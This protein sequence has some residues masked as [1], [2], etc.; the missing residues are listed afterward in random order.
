MISSE[1][2]KIDIHLALNEAFTGFKKSWIILCSLSAIIFLSQSWLPKLLHKYANEASYIKPYFKVF[3]K[4][5]NDIFSMNNADLAFTNLK[6][7]LQI[8]FQNSIN[9]WQFHLFLCKMLLGFIIIFLVLCLLYI[10]TIYISKI[11][12]KKNKVE[13][14][15]KK[16]I[17]KSHLMTFSYLVLSILKVIPFTIAIAI[18]FIYILVNVY[19]AKEINMHSSTA[20][21]YYIVETLFIIFLT[22]LAFIIS[23][24]IYLKLYFTG[25]IITEESANPINAI[26]VSWIMTGSHLRRI[27]Y[28]FLITLV[29]DIISVIT[30]IG[31]VPGTGLKYTLRASAYNQLNK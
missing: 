19:Y 13:N 17:S 9:N 10:M 28:I 30:I 25:F 16:A 6:D 23:I 24:Y 1:N 20:S 5:K 21:I 22:I 11:S 2:R 3:D 29:I 27:F 8:L 14:E 12:V 15:L 4:F 7:S 31:F 18:P 26:K